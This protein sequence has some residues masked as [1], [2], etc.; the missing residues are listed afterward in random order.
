MKYRE[1]G[2]RLEGLPEKVVFSLF[3]QL[4]DGMINLQ[5]HDIVHR[6]IKPSNILLDETEKIIK[7]ADFG[8]AI[9]YSLMETLDQG[10]PLYMAP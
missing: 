5:Q 1:Q 4:L 3:Q 7:I 2:K 8:Q 10:T 6:D 9:D